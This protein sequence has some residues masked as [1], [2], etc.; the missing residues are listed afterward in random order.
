MRQFQNCGGNTA[1]E[2]KIYKLFE[3]SKSANISINKEG[4][5]IIINIF[6]VT[7]HSVLYTCIRFVDLVFI[8][9]FAL[10]RLLEAS[11]GYIFDTEMLLISFPLIASTI[12]HIT[13]G[14][15][16]K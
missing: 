4:Q 3:A 11:N 8:E 2:S 5:E 13:E 14:K 10:F 6:Q 12:G 7:D 1:C 16:S 15:Y 9:I